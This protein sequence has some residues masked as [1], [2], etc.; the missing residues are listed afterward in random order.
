M[1]VLEE[2]GTDLRT[3]VKAAA[4]PCDCEG[5]QHLKADEKFQE[6]VHV[7]LSIY[8]LPHLQLLGIAAGEGA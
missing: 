7:P 2:V 1:T 8:A 5:Q 6:T 4:C 3:G